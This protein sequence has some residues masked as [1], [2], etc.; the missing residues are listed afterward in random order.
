MAKQTFQVPDRGMIFVRR[1][2][3]RCLDLASTRI[4]GDISFTRLR[5]WQN[6]F[7]T[8]TEKYFAACLLDSLIY[9]ST[10]QTVAMLNQLLQVS[11]PDSL[12]RH[13]LL[14]ATE[15]DSYMDAF[16]AVGRSRDLG[17]RFVPVVLK[18]EGPYKSAYTICRMLKQE[19]N[20][21]KRF[22]IA[23]VNIQKEMRKKARILVFIDDITATGLKSRKFINEW[24]RDGLPTGVSAIYAPLVACETAMTQFKQ[25][26]PG[27]LVDC[28]ELLDESY[29]LFSPSS[30]AFNDGVNT[31]QGAKDFYHCLVADR[32]LSLP[33]EFADGFGDLALTYVFSHA[34][35]NNCLPLLWV[36]GDRWESLF[37]R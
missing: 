8:E 27:I 14:S 3:E 37:P 19:C 5:A 23:P 16:T 29:S 13:G 25:Q 31:P 22:I 28:V 26:F 9:R 11:I 4:W 21:N 7:R 24:L 30:L 34:V 20:I 6:N 15:I 35:P 17:I 32:Q 33:K 10:D 2:F 36:T 18:Q 12:R 1:V